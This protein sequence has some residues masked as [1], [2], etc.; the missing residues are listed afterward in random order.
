[1]WEYIAMELPQ[2]SGA[3]LKETEFAINQVGADGW[4][5]VAVWDNVAYFK[6]KKE[7]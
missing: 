1:M 4:E 3:E 2:D 7:G 5:L 6:R